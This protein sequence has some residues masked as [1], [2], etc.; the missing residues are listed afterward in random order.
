V[1]TALDKL[2]RPPT[3]L[4]P[5]L[6]AGDGPAIL[7]SNGAGAGGGE[8]AV[9]KGWHIEHADRSSARLRRQTAESVVTAAVSLGGGGGAT[10]RIEVSDSIDVEGM[11]ELLAEFAKGAGLQLEVSFTAT[12]LSSSH[13][14]TEDIG[15][16][17]GRAL[18][19]IAIERM[20]STGIQGAGSNVDAPEDLSALPVRVGVS[21]EGRKFCKFVPFQEPYD[22]FRR[23]FLVGHTLPNGL[24]SEDL[25][26]FVDAFAGGL[27]AG[28]IVHVGRPVEP[29]TGWPLVFRGLGEAM[30]EVLSE[31]PARRELVPGV[32]G[33]LA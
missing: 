5:E 32:K 23:S 30:A 6:P 9:E 29:A 12:R 15:L 28:V 2:H 3:A 31:N 27:N 11:G 19:A 20:M 1:G 7:A 24:Y 13:V 18:R 4:A 25:D 33:T 14:V 16:A 8:V 22:S 21:I 10:C 26:D 17:L